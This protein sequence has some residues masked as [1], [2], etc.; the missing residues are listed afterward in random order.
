[1]T[2]SRAAGTLESLHTT[3]WGF[4]GQRVV[5]AAART[6]ML[7]E[8]A[9]GARTIEAVAE[10]LDLDPLAAGKIVRALAAAGIAV[11]EGDLYR[12]AD[13]LR[14][15]F[16]HGIDDLTPFVAHVDE[17]SDHWGETLEG[18]LRSGTQP[19]RRRDAEGVRRFGA[20]MRAMASVLGPRTAEALGL[21]GV[22]RALDLGGGLGRYAEAL[23]RASPGLRVTVVDR[24]D[25]VEAGRQALAASEVGRRVDFVGGDYHE[26]DLDAGYDVVLLANVLHQEQPAAAASLVRRAA[27]ALVP[28]GRLAVVDFPIDAERRE[29]LQGALFAINMRS[30]GDTYPAHEI[31]GWMEAAGLVTSEPVPLEPAHWLIVG[32]REMVA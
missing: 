26:V 21:E 13:P 24:P 12:L 25:V 20:A 15:H 17:L 32:R 19:P 18:W 7:R 9:T 23:C 2:G 4:A 14:P 1:M 22:S 11:A 16:A 5:A 6:G 27:S 30:F 10:R 29:V 8:L 3:L 31:R 28:G